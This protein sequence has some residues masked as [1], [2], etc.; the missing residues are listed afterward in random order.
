MALSAQLLWG[1]GL[2]KIRQQLYAFSEL[3]VGETLFVVE[4][5][6]GEIYA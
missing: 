6:N 4:D 3:C 1:I 5:S 2:L